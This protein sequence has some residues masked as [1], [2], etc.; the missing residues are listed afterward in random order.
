[1]SD[2]TNTIE[3]EQPQTSGVKA[4]REKAEQD[5]RELAAAR[6]ELAFLKAGVDLDS[7]MGQVFAKGYD[8]ELDPDA[9]RNEWSEL[10]PKRDEAPPSEEGRIRD[11]FARDGQVPPDAEDFRE[12]PSEQALREGRDVLAKGGSRERA[13]NAYID[14]MV[15][16]GAKKDQRVVFDRDRWMESFG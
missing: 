10:A 7:K 2:D 11:T 13:M 5:A 9:I 3:D 16:A 14:R 1:M 6:R 12:D 4:L 15:D 8:G